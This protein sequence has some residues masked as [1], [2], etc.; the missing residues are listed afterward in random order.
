M[1]N[2]RQ[3]LYLAVASLAFALAVCQILESDLLFA[4]SVR[5]YGILLGYVAFKEFGQAEIAIVVVL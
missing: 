3:E 2:H 1:S 4:P 5:K